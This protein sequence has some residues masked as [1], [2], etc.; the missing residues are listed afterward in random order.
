M[1]A[2]YGFLGVRQKPGLITR[3][4]SYAVTYKLVGPGEE[5]ERERETTRA[6]NW[7]VNLP[8]LLKLFH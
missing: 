1:R 3:F 4:K 7:Q 8:S 5:R 2:T 6:L